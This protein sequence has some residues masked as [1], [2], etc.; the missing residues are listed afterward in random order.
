MLYISFF[1]LKQ[2][3]SIRKLAAR[4]FFGELVWR[5]LVWFGALKRYFRAF[6]F[7]NG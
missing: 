4:C 6:L 7:F 1:C 3:F 5:D 2:V